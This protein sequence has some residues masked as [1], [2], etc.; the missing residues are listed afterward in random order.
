[1]PVEGEV[2][3]K[4]ED[5]ECS[6]GFVGDDELSAVAQGKAEVAVNKPIPFIGE[7]IYPFYVFFA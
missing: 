6:P 5:G 3:E 1:M 4:F 7:N 2:F